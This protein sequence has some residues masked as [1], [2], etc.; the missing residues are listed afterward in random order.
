MTDSPSGS[1]RS[2]AGFGCPKDCLLLAATARTNVV[3]LFVATCDDS[4]YCAILLLF[5]LY[6]TTLLFI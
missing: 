6:I 2:P 1:R 3:S 4:H 5:N